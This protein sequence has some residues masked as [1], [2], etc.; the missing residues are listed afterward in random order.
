M[1]CI[2]SHIGIVCENHGK[3]IQQIK[4]NYEAESN[5][6]SEVCNLFLQLSQKSKHRLLA[7]AYDLLDSE[8]FSGE[9]GNNVLSLKSMEFLYERVRLNSG[10]FF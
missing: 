5:D 8:L 10:F 9:G 3:V 2:D 1:V 4:G 6:T 7:Y